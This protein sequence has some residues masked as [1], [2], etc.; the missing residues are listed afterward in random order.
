M[1]QHNVDELLVGIVKQIKLKEEGLQ[2][3]NNERLCEGSESSSAALRLRRASSPLRT[4]QVAREIL[5]KMC[6]GQ[7]DKVAH[8]RSVS[9]LLV[10]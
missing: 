2:S 9:N 4:L 1:F 6:L 8:Q 3:A 7:G 5:S 10:P